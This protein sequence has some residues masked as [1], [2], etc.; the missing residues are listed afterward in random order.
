MSLLARRN[1]FL[2]PVRLAVT[3]TGMA[4][5]LLLNIIQFGVFLG[6]SDRKFFSAALP[7]GRSP[8]GKVLVGGTG[9]SEEMS[10]GAGPGEKRHLDH[11]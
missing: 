3:L 7:A 5:A 10:G 1:L 9:R 8:G 11:I 2:D 4:F 6:F